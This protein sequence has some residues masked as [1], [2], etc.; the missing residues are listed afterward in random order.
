MG[1]V[2]PHLAHTLK[3][4]RNYQWPATNYEWASALYQAGF[5][6]LGNVSEVEAILEAATWRGEWEMDDPLS[7]AHEFLTAAKQALI[8]DDMDRS[9]HEAVATA[10]YAELFL[11]LG[12]IV[13]H[14]S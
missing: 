6:N 7:A 1:R 8:R 13:P 9:L 2:I 3:N 11:L 10:L 12:I 5:M 14:D 4:W